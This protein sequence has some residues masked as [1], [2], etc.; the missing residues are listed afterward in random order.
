MSKEKTAKKNNIARLFCI[1][2]LSLALFVL[3]S[4]FSLVYLT[5]KE[6][7]ETVKVPCLVGAMLEDVGKYDRFEIES[8]GIYSSEYPVGEIISQEPYGGAERKL[9]A[10]EKVRITVTFCLGREQKQ[11]PHLIGL[12]SAEAASLLRDLGVKVKVIA[13]Y[14]RDGEYGR[15]VRSYPESGSAL[16]DTVTLY[17][18][19]LRVGKAVKVSPYV[20]FDMETAVAKAL[21]DGLY[22][23]DIE[24]VSDTDAPEGRVIWQSIA[25]G[26]FVPR[27]TRISFKV[28]AGAPEEDKHPFGRYANEK[29]E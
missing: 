22:I 25:E 12:D 9:L 20:G 14:D 11:V 4:L 21:G 19:R 10:G 13:V 6:K 16:C 23:M 1:A 18:S 29:S 28:S 27:G 5:G 17:V 7:R 3:S 2:A 26:A 15:V 8:R 24:L